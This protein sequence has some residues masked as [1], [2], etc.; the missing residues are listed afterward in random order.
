M[1][2]DIKYIYNTLAVM[3][4]EYLSTHDMANYN[5]Q[6]T[7]LRKKYLGKPILD[8]FCMNLIISWAPVINQLAEEYRNGVKNG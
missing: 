8:N 4:K 3:Y 2:N 1:G 6:A 5:R 7:E